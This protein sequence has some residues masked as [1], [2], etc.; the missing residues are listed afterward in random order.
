MAKSPK[1]KDYL[2]DYKQGESGK[3]EYSGKS[4][5]YDGTREERKKHMRL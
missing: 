5:I 3:Y 4:Y 2:K 1:R